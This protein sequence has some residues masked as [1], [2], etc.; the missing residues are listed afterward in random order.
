MARR[1][2][3]GPNGS[4]PRTGRGLGNCGTADTVQAGVG[5]GRGGG[6]GRGRGFGQG[7]GFGQG[8]GW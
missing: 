5:Y 2:G 7:A 4:G 3:R 1:D 8:V 6:F